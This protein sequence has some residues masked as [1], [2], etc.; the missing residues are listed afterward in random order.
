MQSSDLS[1]AVHELTKSSS[2]LPSSDDEMKPSV[3][4]SSSISSM[5]NLLRNIQGLLKV[6]ADNASLQEKHSS[7]EIGTFVFKVVII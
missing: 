1:E 7:I 3:S 6:A 5:Q 4:A 2:N